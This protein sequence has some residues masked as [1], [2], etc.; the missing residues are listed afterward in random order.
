MVG[1]TY[2]RYTVGPQGGAVASNAS[3]SLCSVL[4]RPSYADQTTSGNNKSRARQRDTAAAVLFAASL[5]AVRVYSVRSGVLQHTLIPAESK[6]PLEVTTLRVVPLEAVTVSSNPR[7]EE[8]GWMVMVGYQNGHV[9]VFSCGPT[10]NYGLPVCRFYALG[11]KSDT[12]V[13][14]L[15]VDPQRTCMCSGGQDTDLT[16]WDLVTQEASFRLRGHRGGVVGVEFV[17]QEGAAAAVGGVGMGMVVTGAADGLIKV[18]DIGIRQCVQTLVASDA[19]V[20]SICLDSAGRRLYCGL[21]ESQLKV[22]NT[23]ALTKI[24]EKKRNNDEVEEEAMV[25]EHGSIPRKLQKPVTSISFSHDGVFM[26]A[27]TSKTL[28]V[29]RILTREDV[30]KKVSRKRK[31]R[32]AKK[33]NELGDEEEEDNDDNEEEQEKRRMAKNGEIKGETADN[34]GNTN[35][36]SK[37][38]TPHHSAGGTSSSSGPT[39]SSLPTATATEEVVLLRTFFMDEKVRSACFVPPSSTIGSGGG[40]GLRDSGRLHIAVTFNNNNIRTYTTSL[41]TSELEGAATWALDD[42]TQRHTLQEGHQSDIRELLL[43]EDDTALLSLSAEKLMLWNVSITGNQDSYYDGDNGAMSTNP[44]DYYDAKEANVRHPTAVGA[45]TCTS[46]IPLQD[47]VSMAAISP[48][49]CCVGQKDGAVLLVDVPAAAVVFAE[50]GVHVGGVR[51][52]ARRTDGSGFV[53]IGADRR[54]IVWT[55]ALVKDENEKKE[56]GNEDNNNDDDDD[57]DDEERGR[58]GGNRRKHNNNHKKNVNDEDEEEDKKNKHKEGHP[59]K[60][61]V[62]AKPQLLQSMEIELTESPLFLAFSPDN[63]FMA[64]GLQNTNIQLFFAD[65]MKPYLVLFGH[66][67]PPTAAAFSTDGTLVASV[68]MDK[69][70]RLWGTDFGDCHRAI[71]AHDDYVTQVAFLE[72]THQLLTVSLDGSVKH[73]DGDN[74]TMIQVF[75]Q[76]QRGV[77]GLAA[78]ANGTCIATAGMDKCIRCFLRTQDIVF[79]EEEEE[80]MA[81]EAMDEEAAKRTA[82]QTLE[83]QNPEV[84]VAGQVTTA[85]TAAAEKLMEALDLVSIELQRRENREDLAPPHPLLA[86]KSVWEYLWSIIESVRP[87]ELR[88]ALSSLTSTHVDALLNYLETMLEERAVLNYEI[89]AKIVLALVTVSPGTCAGGAGAAAASARA[90]IAGEVSEAHGARRLAAL[91]R[92]ISE[93]LDRTVGR[94][95]YNIAGLQFV[96]QV[97]EDKEKA[98]FFDLSKIQGYKKKYHTRAL[99]SSGNEEKQQQHQQQQRKVR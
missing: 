99:T 85:T 21:R 89:A 35:G 13:L 69:S 12:A 87:S 80:R 40:S 78:T 20:S 3:L 72:G 32:A 24:E 17:P 14:A 5:E 94:M 90:A 8:S 91:R 42:L 76:H 19:Q 74:W 59:P 11:H 34:N 23:E 60:R 93:G 25:V 18:W 6:M 98:R 28:E 16:V 9:A 39:T 30:R 61:S 43:V 27:C 96:R 48:S 55:L 63:R 10:V 88:H 46:H 41:T 15:A 49:L 75:R 92:L 37:K 71:H 31:R 56:D 29:F 73:W 4:A 82:M 77:W 95:D 67:L 44:H 58:R 38:K 51:H 54:L 26:L 70:L 65:T 79:P 33:E 84:G 52:I 64:V 7:I 50:T 45:L 47:A 1:K 62:Q 57:D 2:L 86:N 68:G 81:Q 97:V 22:F 53:T 83:Q 66:K 36:N